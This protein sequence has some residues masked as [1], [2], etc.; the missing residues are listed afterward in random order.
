LLA[1]KLEAISM[2]TLHIRDV[3]DDLA[4]SL[5]ERAARNARSMEAEV[6]ALLADAFTKPRRRTFVEVL[7]AMPNVGEDS[8][9]ERATTN[10]RQ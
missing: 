9:F 3:D 4:Q 7:A 6:R 1:L 2:A 5:R 10:G 8:D